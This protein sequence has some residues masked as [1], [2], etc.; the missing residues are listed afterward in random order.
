MNITL[1]KDYNKAFKNYE[2]VLEAPDEFFVTLTLSC[3]GIVTQNEVVDLK[4]TLKKQTPEIANLPGTVDVTCYLSD[5]L[6]KHISTC[7]FEDIA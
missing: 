4:I 3:S 7:I 6:I 2:F 5:Y 1:T